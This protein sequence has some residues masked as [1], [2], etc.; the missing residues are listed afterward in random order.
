MHSISSNLYVDISARYILRHLTCLLQ[1]SIFKLFLHVHTLSAS[2]FSSNSLAGIHF[3]AIGS[4]PLLRILLSLD[5]SWNERSDGPT[6]TLT[7]K[8]VRQHVGLTLY[9]CLFFS[10]VGEHVQAAD[11][12]HAALSHVGELGINRI[13]E[14]PA[15]LLE[16]S[17]HPST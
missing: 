13:L 9:Q 17:A 12:L 10:H 7:S 3:T 8:V 14:Q 11:Q 1:N 6:T 4:C 16:P 15:R 2:V 5:H